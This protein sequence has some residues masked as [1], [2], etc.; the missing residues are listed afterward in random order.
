MPPTLKF[1][2]ANGLRF[3]YFEEGQG[4]LVLLVHGFPDTAHG[5]D[6]V[7]PAV[8][9]RGFRVVSPFTRGY[10]PTE[11]PAQEDYGSDTLD[12]KSVV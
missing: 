7:R 9:A 8:A 3:A 6:E 10:A 12:R 4:P 11:I 5:W 1:V 2:N